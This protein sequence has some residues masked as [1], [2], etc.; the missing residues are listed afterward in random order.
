MPTAIAGGRTTAAVRPSQATTASYPSSQTPSPEKS[1][2]PR[3]PFSLGSS[4]PTVSQLLARFV[5]YA[6]DF[7]NGGG[8]DD[9]GSPTL[10]RAGPGSSQAALLPESLSDSEDLEGS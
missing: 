6:D 8:G 9:G 2:L 5:D 10:L 7:D 3:E 4:I 1:S